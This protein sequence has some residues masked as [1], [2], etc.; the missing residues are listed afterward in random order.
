M[1]EAFT[2]LLTL[3]SRGEQLHVFLCLLSH[4]TKCHQFVR[5]NG[6]HK[7]A[8]RLTK[9]IDKD[10]NRLSIMRAIPNLA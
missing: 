8:Y 1:L 7:Y 6:R 3:Q 5:K 9:R 4:C 2:H 10:V